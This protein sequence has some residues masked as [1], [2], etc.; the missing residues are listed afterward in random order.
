MPFLAGSYQI[1]LLS[2]PDH[3]LI[4]PI[5][6]QNPY[7][8]YVILETFGCG[9]NTKGWRVH[10]DPEEEDGR[11]RVMYGLPEKIGYIIQRQ[12]LKSLGGEGCEVNGPV[13]GQ[14]IRLFFFKSKFFTGLTFDN[15]I[16]IEEW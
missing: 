5:Q 14:K 15:N 9:Y 6:F 4:I 16:H 13:K 1:G 7:L 8:L 11:C 3:D 2:T 10:Y 12:S